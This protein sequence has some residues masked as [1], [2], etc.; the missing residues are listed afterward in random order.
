[1]GKFRTTTTA[2]EHEQ[3]FEHVDDDDD[4]LE[5]LLVLVAGIGFR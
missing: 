2:G 3:V 1:M 5:D 4:V